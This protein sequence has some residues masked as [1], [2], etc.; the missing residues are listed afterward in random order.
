MAWGEVI[1]TCGVDMLGW[2]QSGGLQ[3]RVTGRGWRLASK[4]ERDGQGGMESGGFQVE[5]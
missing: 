1:E 5:R 3:G 2:M 4:T